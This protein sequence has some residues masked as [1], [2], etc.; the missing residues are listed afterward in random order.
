MLLEGTFFHGEPDK[1]FRQNQ[2]ISTISIIATY[3][4]DIEKLSN[5]RKNNFSPPPK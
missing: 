3:A 1:N 2:K 4:F 5:V